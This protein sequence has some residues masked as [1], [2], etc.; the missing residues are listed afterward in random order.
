MNPSASERNYQSGFGNHFASEA[1]P[2]ACRR[3][4]TARSASPHGLYAELLSGTAF[5]APRADNRRTWMYRRL[6]SVVTGAYEPYAQADW[7]SGAAGGVV[8][9][10]DPLRWH[11][12]RRCR[13]IAADFIDGLRT[14]VAN[15]DAEAQTGIAA[16]V[17]AAN[18]SME[19]RALV[20]A[21][22]EMLIVPQQGR[23][24][25]HHRARRAGGA[26]RARSRCVPRGLAFKVELPDG[27]SR[28]YVCENYGAA[29]PP[30]RA[31]AD[32]LQR[33]G[34]RARLPG[35]GGRLRDRPKARYEIVRKFGG[36]LWRQPPA[37]HAVQRRRLARQPG[38]AE[39][40]HRATS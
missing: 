18:R 29:V 17:Y 32:R 16:L 34:Q 35:A 31:G 1:V 12:V 38:A 36:R 20:N 30:A 33:A 14:V 8:V 7:T 24:R 10:P 21:D 2:G 22:G 5:T 9:P 23:L 26:R 3:G 11:P 40:R 4:A 28:G 27:P 6:P 25:A 15:G 13:P 19:R 39:V 37:R